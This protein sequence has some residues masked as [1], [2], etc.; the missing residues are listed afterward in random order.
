MDPPP[1]PCSSS[2][3]LSLS[4]SLA[5]SCSV[6]F[7]FFFPLPPPLISPFSF[8]LLPS[9]SLS[10]SLSDSIFY[11]SLL[12]FITLCLYNYLLSIYI[13]FSLALFFSIYLQFSST[14]LLQAQ[15]ITFCHILWLWS[16]ITYKPTIIFI[17]IIWFQQMF[18]FESLT[19]ILYPANTPTP[20]LKG[21]V[22]A[23]V[24]ISALV[25]AILVPEGRLLICIQLSIKVR[26]AWPAFAKPADCCR[27]RRHESGAE[28]AAES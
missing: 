23:S 6:L 21:H 2:S 25:I 10:L 22:P 5:P 11:L 4:L 26:A 13:S 14:L 24:V 7:F 12:L 8:P 28:T 1:P 3:S 16:F 9:I 27:S 18:L 17:I 20:L 19:G 15:L